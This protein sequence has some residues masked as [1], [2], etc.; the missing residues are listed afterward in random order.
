MVFEAVDGGGG[1]LLTIAGEALEEAA[2]VG[3]FGFDELA[4]QRE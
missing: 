4:S 2:R 1:R 3:D